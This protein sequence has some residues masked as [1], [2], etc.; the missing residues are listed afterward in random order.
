MISNWLIQRCGKY[1]TALHIAHLLISLTMIAVGVFPLVYV[2]L[3]HKASEGPKAPST[4]TESLVL[5]CIIAS[6]I[7]TALD[8]ML[9]VVHSI[10]D[11]A[12]KR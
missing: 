3:I 7:T 11:L 9:G 10:V 2:Y 5:V 6:L 12:T 1:L 4:T 8:G